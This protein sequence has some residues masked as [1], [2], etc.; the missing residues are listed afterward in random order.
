MVFHIIFALLIALISSHVITGQ[1][2]ATLQD[3]A[4]GNIYLKGFEGKCAEP[5]TEYLDCLSTK[6]TTGSSCYNENFDLLSCAGNCATYFPPRGCAFSEE[7]IA[8]H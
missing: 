8:L 5:I 4:I 6:E 2:I 7:A 1:A 3:G